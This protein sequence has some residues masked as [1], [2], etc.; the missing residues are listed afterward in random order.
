[1]NN[2]THWSWLHCVHLWCCKT[3]NTPT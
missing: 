1:M 3:H 2:R